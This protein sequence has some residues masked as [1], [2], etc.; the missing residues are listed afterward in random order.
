MRNAMREPFHIHIA[1]R[2]QRGHLRRLFDLVWNV[3]HRRA[4]QLGSISELQ[5]V[6]DLDS[7]SHALVNVLIDRRGCRR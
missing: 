5:S 6:M 7:V 3:Q 4:L 1:F 2:A